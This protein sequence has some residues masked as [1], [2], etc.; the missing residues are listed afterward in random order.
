MR[1]KVLIGPHVEDRRQYETGEVVEADRNLAEQFGESWQLDK[2]GKKVALIKPARFA[3]TDEPASRGRLVL[4]E[5][6]HKIDAS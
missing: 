4:D 5:K 6:G 1:F 2:D 3:V